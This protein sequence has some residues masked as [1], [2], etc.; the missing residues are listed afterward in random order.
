MNGPQKRIFII[1]PMTEE[2][3][4]PT[5]IEW[6]KH[7]PNIAT[8]TRKVLSA[9]REKLGDSLAN[10]SVIQPAYTPDN[11]PREVFSDI[12]HCDL[13]IADLSSGSPN[14][15]YEL[16]M[17]HANGVPVILINFKDPILRQDIFYLNQQNV[18]GVT[19][20]EEQTLF[21]ALAAGSLEP[22]SDGQ[23]GHLEHILTAHPEREYWNPIT[24]HFD[25]VPLVN[26]A[27]ATGIA[28]GQHY[29]FLKWVLEDGGIFADHKRDVEK[30]ILLRP[31]RIKN[32]DEIK[33]KLIQRF[34]V[35]STDR[36]GNVTRDLPGF[37]YKVKGHPRG[38]YF[39]YQVGRFLIDYPTPISSLSVSRQYVDMMNYVKQRLSNEDELE[40]PPLEERLIRI[41]F[42]TLENLAKSPQNSCDWDRVLVLPLKRALQILEAGLRA[43]EPSE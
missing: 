38:G 21:N 42:Q 18:I 16:S 10:Y 19:D 4:D 2:V 14:V 37:F 28:T 15:I 35:D 20:F 26:V 29:N 17:L 33:K 27:A 39:V 8:A 36:Q 13:A 12:M 3:D 30:I 22:N 9:L 23:K 40:L 43:P 25:G 34:G 31:D 7:I 24:Q 41:Y 6:S 5:G 11:I 1:G 32:V